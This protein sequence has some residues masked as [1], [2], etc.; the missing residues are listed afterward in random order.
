MKN[1][2]KIIWLVIILLSYGCGA[3]KDMIDL[4]DNYEANYFLS[5][6]T[7][8]HAV[9]KEMFDSSFYINIF[10]ISDSSIT[11]KNNTETEQVLSSYLITIIPDG[12]YYT[13]SKLI[14]IE[15]LMNP[16]IMKIVEFEYP[17]FKIVIEY[18]AFNN[19]VKQDYEIVGI[20]E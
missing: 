9:V 16:K 7:Q 2:K 3:Q 4:S 1:F 18:G 11:Q 19:R 13:S 14:K 15:G 6:I 12:D 10:E 17:R 5:N 20:L 8:C